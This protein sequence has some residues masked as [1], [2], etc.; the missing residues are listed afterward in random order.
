MIELDGARSIESPT[1]VPTVSDR[2]KPRLK[3]FLQ[4]LAALVFDKRRALRGASGC[5]ACVEYQYVAARSARA[6][7]RAVGSGVI[8]SSDRSKDRCGA[9][10]NPPE[11][12]LST[13]A[14]ASAS[15]PTP[16]FAF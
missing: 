4:A 3:F 13:P 15:I 11:S 8:K 12:T 2:S 14:Q 5:A 10:A 1:A 6:Y 16:R 9:N 7:S